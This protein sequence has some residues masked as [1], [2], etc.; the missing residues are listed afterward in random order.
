VLAQVS[1]EPSRLPLSLRENFQLWISLAHGPTTVS[2]Y[3]VLFNGFDREYAHC[4]HLIP[5]DYETFRETAGCVY[6]TDRE[7]N[8]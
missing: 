4:E 7:T 2:T 8:L 6:H 3:L 5:R 1:A